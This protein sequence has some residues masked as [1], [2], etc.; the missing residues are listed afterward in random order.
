[1]KKKFQYTLLGMVLGVSCC[2]QAVIAQDSVAAHSLLRQIEDQQ[3]RRDPFFM[4]GIFPSYV[5]NKKVYR[6]Q[7]KDNNVFYT[8][9]ISY[10][11]KKLRPGL[12]ASDQTIVDSIIARSERA[13]APFKNRE[14][15]E[16]YNFWRTDS[17]YRLPYLW[18]LNYTSK[19]MLEDDPDCTSICLLS[20][21]VPGQTAEKAHEVM[22]DFVNDADNPTQ[23]T[24]SR[25]RSYEAYSTWMGNRLPVVFD[26]CVLSNVLTFVQE[27]NLP[28]TKADSA[29]LDL[30]V[31][32]INNKDHIRH[33]YIVAPYYGGSSIILYHLARL[34]SIKP[35]PALEALKDSLI[36]DA[37]RILLQ[38]HDGFEKI[39]L[40]NALLKW[41]AGPG[42]SEAGTPDEIG[43]S[44][45]PFFIGNIPS[46]FNFILKKPLSKREIGFYYHYCPAYNNVLLLEYVVLRHKTGDNNFTF[47]APAIK[48]AV[49]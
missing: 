21:N 36:S 40:S 43:K 22:Q 6:E 46:I 4:P 31:A 48:K 41:N 15:R 23:T 49:E 11:L 26:I 7:R 28:W 24:F 14:G 25:Y 32:T 1:M 16:T 39:V 29:S 3:L 44:N 17:A 42:I 45:T 20:L 8:A 2:F 12:P 5:S 34:M 35:V 30:I 37:Q 9:L 27:Y 47:D 19:N 38:T 18:G 33:P 13:V 10:T